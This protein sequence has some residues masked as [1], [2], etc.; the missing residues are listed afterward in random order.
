MYDETA[1]YNDPGAEKLR[2]PIKAR[3]QEMFRGRV[4][5]EI[6]CATGY[7]TRVVGETAKSVLGVDINP[8]VIKVAEAR[9]RDLSNVKFQRADAY[10]LKGVPRGFTAAMGILWWSHIPVNRIPG[11]LSSLHSRLEPGAFVLFVDQLPYDGH[12]RRRDG[13]GNTIEQRILSDGQSFEIVKNFPAEEDIR[14]ALAGIAENIQ[15][16]EHPDENSWNVTYNVRRNRD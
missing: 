2:A 11:F 10:T 5:L 14:N 12:V 4:V 16:A 15:Y 9:C 13:E 7:W 8:L 1:G 3:Y 6:A